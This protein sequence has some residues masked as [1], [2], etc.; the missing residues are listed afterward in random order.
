MAGDS[1]PHNACGQILFFL[2]MSK[3]NYVVKETPYSAYV[4]IRKKFIQSSEGLP[5]P[6]AVK[7]NVEEVE[8][9]KHELNIL[10]VKNIELERRIALAVIDLEEGET[11][12]KALER[13][14]AKQD[15]TIEEA[16]EKNRALICKK[17]TIEKE[18]TDLKV[19]FAYISKQKE[20]ICKINFKISKLLF[21][22]FF[23][24]N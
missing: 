22:G 4:T 17:E 6:I 20:N 2:K 15:D 13:E 14:N 11:R 18:L 10:R 1:S 24:T 21:N 9:V 5:E 8:K 3:L 19:D 23:F 16:Y 12:Y 7:T